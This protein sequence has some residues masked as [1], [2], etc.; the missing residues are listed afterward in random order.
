[1]VSCWA[2]K[3]RAPGKRGLFIWPRGP[4]FKLYRNR[5]RVRADRNPGRRRRRGGTP[6]RERGAA[7]GGAAEPGTRRPRRRIGGR[8]AGNS[9]GERTP[10]NRTPAPQDAGEGGPP[11]RGKPRRAGAEPRTT[12]RTEPLNTPAH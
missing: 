5:H 4:Y 9:P 8:R 1:L 12:P 7:K 3:M 11:N 10:P 6:T 2:H